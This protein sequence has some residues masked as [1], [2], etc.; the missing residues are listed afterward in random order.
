MTITMVRYT[1]RPEQAAAN[2]E[3]VRAVYAEL[4]ATQP[5]GLR[6]AT[7]RAE[8]GVGFVHLAVNEADTGPSPLTA[9]PAFRRFQEGIRERCADPPV[10]IELR[11]VG[12][13]GLLGA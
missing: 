3:L 1:V 6:Y 11:Q 10:A 9:V 7:F 12:A 4:H 5:H 2:E 13:F 8:D